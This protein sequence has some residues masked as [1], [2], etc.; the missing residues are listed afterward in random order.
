MT[1]LLK[2]IFDLSLSTKVLLGFALGIFSGVFFGE[3]MAFLKLPGDAFIQLLQMTVLP[4]IIL[5]LISG[6]GGLNHDEAL[7][8]AKKVGLLLLL[9]WA[10]VIATILV[11]PLAYPTWETASFFSTTLIQVG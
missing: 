5:S 6:L 10:L 11:I 8:L 9:L 7:S 3:M 1:T 2:K 4:Y